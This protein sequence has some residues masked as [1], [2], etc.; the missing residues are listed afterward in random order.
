MLGKKNKK[1]YFDF[2][3]TTPICDEVK[4]AMKEA[5]GIFA[6]P[7]SLYASGVFAKNIVKDSRKKVAEILNGRDEEI[8]FTSGGTESNNLAIFGLYNFLLSENVSDLQVAQKRKF[9]IITSTIEHSSVLEP[10]RELEKRGVDVTFVK[11]DE[12]GVIDPADIR[13]AIREETFLVSIMY[14]NNEIGTI[15]PIKQIAKCIRD[16]RKT[17]NSQLSTINYPLLHTDASQAPN[18]LDIDVVALGVDMMT[19]DGGKI[20]G[21]KGVGALFRRKSAPLSPLFFGGGQEMGLRS[22]TENISLICGFSKALEV[23]ARLKEK[24]SKRLSS[25]KNYFIEKIT[26]KFPEVSI[27]GSLDNRLPNN[28]NIC[29]PNLDSEFAVFQLDRLGIE[30]SSAS[31]CV[32][33]KEDN[34]SYVIR[35]IG[36]GECSRSSL[37]FTLGRSTTKKDINHCLKAISEIILQRNSISN[38]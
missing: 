9:H 33:L 10:I 37:R 19:L 38:I 7:G 20:Y 35:A 14:V 17:L 25:L 5:E 11:P 26:K 28:V 27:N 30:C 12:F 22:G 32:N 6:N 34:Y 2:A 3:S 36:R 4:K 23:S 18:Y 21:P 16:F 1:T 29:I 31:T 24:E 15:Q 13:K 8:I